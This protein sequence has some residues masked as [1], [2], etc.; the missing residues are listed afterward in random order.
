VDRPAASSQSKHNSSASQCSSPAIKQIK[1]QLIINSDKSRFRFI[2]DAKA[3]HTPSQGI[4]QNDPC[5]AGR[6]ERPGEVAA[7]G[8]QVTTT[9]TTTTTS[10]AGHGPPRRGRLIL[11]ANRG[12][13][14]LPLL[15]EGV[16][17]RQNPNPKS[18]IWNEPG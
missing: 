1:N 17:V 5:G 6:V 11:G 18:V 10:R 12:I 3:R 9:T 13:P 7:N 2:N 4:R 14:P 15:E 8:Y 16:D